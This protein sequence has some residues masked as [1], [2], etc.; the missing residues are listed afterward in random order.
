MCKKSAFVPIRIFMSGSMV[1]SLLPGILGKVKRRPAPCFT[2]TVPDWGT[3]PD[4]T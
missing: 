2:K 4:T 3:K 1:A